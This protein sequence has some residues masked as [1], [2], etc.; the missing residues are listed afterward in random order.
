MGSGPDGREWMAMMRGLDTKVIIAE[1]VEMKV[2]IPLNMQEYYYILPSSP[3]FSFP[4]TIS[5]MALFHLLTI[6]CTM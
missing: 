4:E 6:R 3:C 1:E 2:I 5:I